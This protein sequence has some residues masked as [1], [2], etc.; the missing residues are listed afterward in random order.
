MSRNE[1]ANAMLLLFMSLGG[2]N[3]AYEELNQ[4]LVAKCNKM[5]M[6]KWQNIF[7]GKL[8]WN[9]ECSVHTFLNKLVLEFNKIT[10]AFDFVTTCMQFAHENNLKIYMIFSTWKYHLRFTM[11]LKPYTHLRPHLWRWFDQ[12][13]V[14][15]ME[16]WQSIEAQTHLLTWPFETSM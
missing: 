2:N 12:T 5:T 11:V 7:L 8:T 14:Q 15:G 16:Q 4:I 6:K 13:M 10:L 1:I 3:D 9:Y